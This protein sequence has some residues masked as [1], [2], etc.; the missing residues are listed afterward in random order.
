MTYQREFVR[1]LKVG[2]VGV[3]SHAYRNL[4]PAMNY[5]PVSLQAFCDVDKERCRATAAQYGVKACFENAVDMY[6]NVELDA[7][8]L[9]VSPTVHPELAC[10][11]F[12]AGLHVWLEK[13]PARWPHEISE[14]IRHRGDRVAV[15]G[16]KKVFMP[17]VEKVIEIFSRP[18][19]GPLQT[20]LAEYPMTIP[21][22]GGEVLK[23][24]VVAN[25]LRNGCHP[26]S[27]C[28]AV[29]GGV[30]AVT[31]HRA[32]DGSGICVLEFANGAIG[33]FHMI[34]GP[35]RGQPVERYSFASE[36]AHVVV[37]NGSRVIFNRGIPF[38]YGRNTSFAPEGFDHGALVW[39]PQ[40][41]EGTLEN[42]SLFTQGIYNEM[43]YFCSCILKNEMPEKGS[44]EFALQVM[45]VYEGAL[46]SKG[47]R[48]DLQE[49]AIDGTIGDPRPKCSD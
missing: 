40:N 27:L 11:A 46:L 5:L 42:K 26:L 23:S 7:V 29:G 15:V 13:P 19:L 8:L 41:R 10:A 21:E 1:K 37:E 43:Q 6:R 16:F 12:D 25:W 33:N 32:N 39:E 48:V 22:D 24:G 45:K 38:E 49:F 18:E 4:L 34:S 17:A 2:M 20:I 47:K 9:S 44:L 30:S 28:M 31:V 35:N 14:M 36:G 3:G